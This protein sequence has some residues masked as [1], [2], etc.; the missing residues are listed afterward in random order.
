MLYTDSGFAEA[1]RET[2]AACPTPDDEAES[3]SSFTIY[4]SGIR[5][6]LAPRG[7]TTGAGVLRLRGGDVPPTA[8]GDARSVRMRRGI[9]SICIFLFFSFLFLLDFVYRMWCVIFPAQNSA[10]MYVCIWAWRA[11]LNG[12][13]WVL[14]NLSIDVQTSTILEIL[15]PGSGQVHPSRRLHIA[16]P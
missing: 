8:T 13:T 9:G 14:Y 5:L 6:T 12:G 4:R 3:S 1:S 10:R 15:S 7:R 2:T 11:G 16:R